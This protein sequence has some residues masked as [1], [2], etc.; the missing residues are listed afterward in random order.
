MRPLRPNSFHAM[1]A[2]ALDACGR[3]HVEA[4][5]G[6]SLSMI[7]RWTDPDEENGRRMPAPDLDLLCRRFPAAATVVAHHFA[8]IAGGFF[9]PVEEGD[10][11]VAAAA[12]DFTMRFADTASGVT[13]ALGL[14]SKL[15]GDLTPE[16]AEDVHARIVQTQLS[17]NRLSAIVQTRRAP[18]A[19]L[20]AVEAGGK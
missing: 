7:S 12:S 4:E 16:E 17:L 5:L 14:G 15:P 18:Q 3:K 9:L 8:G 13:A 6:R 2:E 10:G 19:R 1:L 20:R 11:D